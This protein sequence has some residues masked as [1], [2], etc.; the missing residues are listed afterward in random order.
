MYILYQQQIFY[1]LIIFIY[2]LEFHSSDYKQLHIVFTHSSKHGSNISSTVNIKLNK[3]SNNPYYVLQCDDLFIYIIYFK[4][5][6]VFVVYY[7]DIVS[8]NY[9]SVVYIILHNDAAL[10][11]YATLLLC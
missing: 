3:L 1:L 5:S 8:N 7:L 10:I 2:N 6:N 4:I 11:N 9:E